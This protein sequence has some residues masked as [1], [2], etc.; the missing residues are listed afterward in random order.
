MIVAI[1]QK[2]GVDQLFQPLQH[3]LKE[4]ERQDQE[5]RFNGGEFAAKRPGQ[6]S[7]QLANEREIGAEP[8]AGWSWFAVEPEEDGT[9]GKTDQR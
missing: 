2:P 9:D 4:N 8:E 5:D 1:A 7:L 3:R 6:E